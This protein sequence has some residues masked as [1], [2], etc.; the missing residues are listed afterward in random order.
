MQQSRGVVILG[1]EA[2]DDRQDDV[3]AIAG[4]CAVWGAT[5]LRELALSRHHAAVVDML[6]SCPRLTSLA[7][8]SASSVAAALAADLSRAVSNIGPTFG[9]A[10]HTLQVTAGPNGDAEL[11]ALVTGLPQLR[12]LSLAGN[13]DAVTIEAWRR[14]LLLLLGRLEV[15]ELRAASGN[16]FSA[17]NSLAGSDSESA[18]AAPPPCLADLPTL[19]LR[20]LSLGKYNMD[21]DAAA[22]IASLSRHPAQSAPL[23]LRLSEVTPETWLA[24]PVTVTHLRLDARNLDELQLTTIL[25]RTRLPR[26]RVLELASCHGIF[27][28]DVMYRNAPLGPAVSRSPLK[29][30]SHPTLRRLA[31]ECFDANAARAAAREAWAVAI[32]GPSKLSGVADSPVR[33]PRLRYVVMDGVALRGWP[34]HDPFV[35]VQQPAELR[36]ILYRIAVALAWIVRR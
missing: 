3:A 15:L 5:T 23:E 8:M 29:D 14:S 19:P 2:W 17:L 30:A 31:L 11:D 25:D 28:F 33:F 35:P 6:R 18:A 9:M 13:D 32:L 34:L 36:G 24:A 1:A 27:P 7:V 16:A 22:F 26:L 20:A 4:A 21:G 10:L 12:T